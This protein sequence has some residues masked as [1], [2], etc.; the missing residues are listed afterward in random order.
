MNQFTI[1]AILKKEQELGNSITR[2]D[3]LEHFK[4]FEQ[5]RVNHLRMVEHKQHDPHEHGRQVVRYA[6][7]LAKSFNLSKYEVELIACAARFHDIGKIRID[8]KI[9]NKPA[10]LYP[11]EKSKVEMHTI[12]GQELLSPFTY[13]ANLVRHHHERYDGKGYPD[14]ISGTDIPLGS[15]IIAVIDAFNAMTHQRTYNI[16][17]TRENAVAELKKCAG[18]QFDPE[19]VERFIAILNSAWLRRAI[20]FY[21]E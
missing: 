15:R 14:N 17:K 4:N 21:K 12:Y 7:E 10:P 9:L 11:E 20:D 5:M 16:V 13:I 3:I 6:K 18:Q 8:E 19:V 1:R 2:D